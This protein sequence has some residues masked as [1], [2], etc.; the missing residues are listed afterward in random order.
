MPV[1][2]LHLVRLLLIFLALQ[3]SNLKLSLPSLWLWPRSMV[4]RSQ[5]ASHRSF[6]IQPQ[7]GRRHVMQPV[8]ASNAAPSQLRHSVHSSLRQVLVSNKT[9]PITWSTSPRHSTMTRTLSS[10]LRFSLS[11]PVI[12][13]PRK[14]FPTANKPR[15]TLS[16][17]GSFSV[18]I[19]VTTQ[20][21][22]WVVWPWG[23]MG[24]S[25]LACQVP[26]LQPGH[27]KR[28]LA[29]LSRMGLS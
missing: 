20:R 7:N 16:S 15:G 9:Q 5:N 19:R 13:P 26:S 18:S 1:L 28:T 12:L 17:T 3:W 21:L 24:P 8:G 22:L 14:A 4:H 25:H 27:A 23:V 10:S 29:A 11:S 2:Q 6:Q